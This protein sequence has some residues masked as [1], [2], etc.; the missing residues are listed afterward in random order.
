MLSSQDWAELSRC[1]KL[2]RLIHSS[3]TIVVVR[4]I[5]E[6]EAVLRGS[7]AQLAVIMV[8]PPY[9]YLEAIALAGVQQPPAD[10]FT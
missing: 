8:E 6:A 4:T 3:A 5:T 9:T 10:S 7:W 1:G 2:R